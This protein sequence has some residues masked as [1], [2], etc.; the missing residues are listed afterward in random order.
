MK[1]LVLF[2]SVVLNHRQGLVVIEERKAVSRFSLRSRL[3]ES[4]F[5]KESSVS[6]RSI[7]STCGLQDGEFLRN[8]TSCV[9]FCLVLS[10]TFV[11]KTID[12]GSDRKKRS[13]HGSPALNVNL[14]GLKTDL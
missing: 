12:H 5:W 10:L 2:V 7:Q 13:K 4:S 6:G 9:V 8:S 14:K 11:Q 1:E 3:F